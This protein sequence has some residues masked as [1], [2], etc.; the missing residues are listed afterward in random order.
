MKTILSALVIGSFLIT[1]S[2]ALAKK[3]ASKPYRPA[4]FSKKQ[5]FKSSKKGDGWY[6]G[7]YQTTGW[8]NSVSNGY[9]GYLQGGWYSR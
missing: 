3:N 1:G 8:H 5:S 9:G 4:S 7:S 2:A 6:N